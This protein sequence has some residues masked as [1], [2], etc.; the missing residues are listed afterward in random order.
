MKPSTLY[1]FPISGQLSEIKQVYQIEK[2]TGIQ[3]DEE[4]PMNQAYIGIL[5]QDSF[6][7]YELI[8]SAFDHKL[9]FNFIKQIVFSFRF[10]GNNICFLEI[11]GKKD[12]DIELIKKLNRTD[13][14]IFD[15]NENIQL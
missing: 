14:I 7:I 12:N 4:K 9:K 3:Q 1:N 6:L 2:L 10:S 8:L 13:I 5:C 15:E 11:P